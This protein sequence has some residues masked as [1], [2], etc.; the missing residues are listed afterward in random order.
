MYAEIY[1]VCSCFVCLVCVCL[2]ERIFPSI[3][4]Q[5]IY[6]VEIASSSFA[7]K[8]SFEDKFNNFIR[9]LVS[10]SVPISS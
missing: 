4:M 1:N 5:R 9:K 8:F 10:Y 2:V 3:M 7:L 6:I